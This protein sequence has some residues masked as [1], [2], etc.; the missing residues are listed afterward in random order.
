MITIHERADRPS[1][2][3]LSSQRPERFRRS[4][5]LSW[6]VLGAFLLAFLTSVGA[7]A[8]ESDSSFTINAYLT[9]AYGEVD[10]A[11]IFGIPEDGTFDYGTGAVLLNYRANDRNRFVLQVAAERLGDSPL[12]EIR[13]DVEIDWLFYEHVFPTD[14]QVRLGR[15]PVPY[16]IYNEIRDAG[17]LLEFYR[18][19]V[20]IYFEGAFS[21]ETVDGVVISQPIFRTASWALEAD[22]YY[23]EWDRA[24]YIAPNVF[25]GTAEDAYGVQLWLETPISGLRFGAAGQHF[26]QNGGWELIRPSGTTTDFDLALFSIDADLGRFY[27]R[28]EW[29]I[30]ETNFGL[31]GDV[32]IPA[33][34]AMAGFRITDTFQITAMY[35]HSENEGELFSIDPLYED[36]AASLIYR[37]RP[38]ML[39]RLEY[40][41]FESNAADVPTPF[42]QPSVESDILILSVSAAF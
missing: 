41:Q 34:Y 22:A 18:P 27:A 11:P 32:E 13:D 19:P 36:V 6:L 3:A 16:G 42:G 15:V 30:L 31:L 39:A 38:N 24:E 35:E 21:S 5:S 2:I 23:G 28:A 33:Y 26:E 29:Q 17:V 37:F 1:P 40:H 8:E 20:G 4:L 10:G 25:D 7:R 14:T 12:K 9:L